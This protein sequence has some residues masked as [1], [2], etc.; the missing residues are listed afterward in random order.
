VPIAS[1]LATAVVSFAFAL[2]GVYL[3]SLLV[4]ALAPTFDGRRTRSRH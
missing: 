2:V 4:N 3:V 1:G